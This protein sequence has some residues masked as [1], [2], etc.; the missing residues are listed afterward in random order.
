MGFN[1]QTLREN[2]TK[3]KTPIQSMGINA[4]ESQ[5]T[6]EQQA[7]DNEVLFIIDI[8]FCIEKVQGQIAIFYY[9]SMYHSREI[10]YCIR[11]RI[12]A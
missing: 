7:E 3:T 10:P 4:T 1:D 9:P 12:N 6:Q 11:R 8:C 5:N 2:D